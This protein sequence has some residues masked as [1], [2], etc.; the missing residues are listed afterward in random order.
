MRGYVKT[1]NGLV[2]Y[3]QAGEGG[4]AIVFYHEAPLSSAIYEPAMPLLGRSFRAFAFDTPGHG[5]SRGL[6]VSATSL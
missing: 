1:S 3:R 6:A 2:H 4:P 5:F